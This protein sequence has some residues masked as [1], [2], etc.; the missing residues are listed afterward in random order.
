MTDVPVPVETNVFRKCIAKDPDREAKMPSKIVD[1]ASVLF[2]NGVHPL[3]DRNVLAEDG[4]LIRHNAEDDV[5][6]TAKILKKYVGRNKVKKT[7]DKYFVFDCKTDGTGGQILSVCAKV[8]NKTLDVCEKMFY[9]SLCIDRSSIIDANAKTNIFPH[10]DEAD[11][12]FHNEEELLKG[13]WYFWK[14][15]C[16]NCQ[17]VTDMPENVNVLF[18]RCIAKEPSRKEKAPLFLIHLPSVLSSNGIN[19]FADRKVVA[20][21]NN[22]DTNISKD[23]VELTAEILKKYETKKYF[24]FDCKTDGAFGQTL[25]ICA[26]VYDESLSK[27]QNSFYGVLDTTETNIHNDDAKTKI[28]PHIKDESNKFASAEEL[29]EEFWQFW[30]NNRAGCYC[31]TNN[32]FPVGANVLRKCVEI[33]VTSR[34]KYAPFPLIDLYSMLF[35]KN[36]KDPF[37]DENSRLQKEKFNRNIAKD[38][39]VVIAESLNRCMIEDEKNS[40][41]SYHTFFFPFVYNESK[42]FAQMCKL[43]EQQE[44]WEN[45]DFQSISSLRE[46][47]Y[48]ISG[49]ENIEENI[50]NGLS[51]EQKKEKAK[52]QKK[53][54]SDSL[55]WDYQTFQYFNI[56]A[57][58]AIFGCDSD[59]V[60]NYRFMLEKYYD[61]DKVYYTI[62]KNNRNYKLT[63]HSVKIKV[64]NTGIAVFS[65][66]CENYLNKSIIDVKYINEYGRRIFYPFIPSGDFTLCAD[67]ISIT[68]S[69]NNQHRRDITDDFIGLFDV[70]GNGS[71]SYQYT[72][73]SENNGSWAI[74]AQNEQT[75]KTDDGKKIQLTNV[76]NIIETFLDF[77]GNGDKFTSNVDK[78]KQKDKIYIYPAIDDRMFVACIVLDGDYGDRVRG[79]QSKRY[80]N[81]KKKDIYAFQ[82]E[83]GVAADLYELLYIDT[84][85][86]VSCPSASMMKQLLNDQIYMRW[87]DYGTVQGLTHHS[88]IEV[89]RD[90]YGTRES[91]INPFLIEYTQ[92]VALCLA[93][94]ASIMA[95]QDKATEIAKAMRNIDK[96]TVRKTNE[97][98]KLQSQYT[99]FMN[100]VYFVEITAQEQGVE[101]YDMM[102]EAMYIEKEREILESQIDKMSEVANTSLDVD[103]NH[104]GL[105]IAIVAL[106]LSVSGSLIDVWG[107]ADNIINLC[108]GKLTVALAQPDVFIALI[109]I[110]LI[111]VFIS[112]TL[113]WRQKH[114]IRKWVKKHKHFW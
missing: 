19:P 55:R 67:K 6:I 2:A 104:H 72:C 48:Y 81:M 29:L 54:I 94:R 77:G 40:V 59:I 64:Y 73:S 24:V 88:F 97:L 17:C 22:L 38:E 51:E 44:H 89:V 76:P 43:F 100:E 3:V 28:F 111:I 105:Y 35:A 25:S 75:G 84:A 65:F 85:G 39:V 107:F 71:N 93:Q 9:G 110:E 12:R 60:H 95:F 27:S 36:M 16:E 13:F 63:L 34:E 61:K 57:R 23:C 45:A 68:G 53:H 74:L 50:E 82:R 11:I 18:D 30:K 92:I 26:T 113:V 69:K 47:D 41:Y 37:E 56:P 87:L 106:I 79:S 31:I 42:T 91:V 86:N 98:I 7:L 80:E 8:Y 32:P 108:V 78:K 99:Q 83:Y 14:N 114:G 112:I 1:L 58:R 4:I 109:I 52:Q 21:N 70:E 33:D 49:N 103:L 5:K 10:L 96:K 66:E 46:K 102:K 62:Y 101:M 20:Q 15:N 90:L